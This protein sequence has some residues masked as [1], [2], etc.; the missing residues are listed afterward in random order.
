MIGQTMSVRE[1][2]SFLK[3]TPRTVRDWISH[4]KLPASKVGR[5]YI[6]PAEEVGRLITPA[7][8]PKDMRVR[9]AAFRTLLR[10][11]GPVDKDA[12]TRDRQLE[13]E[14]HSIRGPQ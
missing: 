10:G 3:V 5:F 6:I 4:G 9:S 12:F 2:A 8:R 14:F 13:Q 1:A 11:G 7:A